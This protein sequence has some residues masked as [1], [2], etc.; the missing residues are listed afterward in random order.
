MLKEHLDALLLAL[1]SSTDNFMVGLSV[2]IGHTEL[3]LWVNG[4]ISVCNATGA[5]IAGYGGVMLS[6]HM[7]LLAPILASLAFALLALQEFRSSTF[8]SSDSA[9]PKKKFLEWSQVLQLALP[10]T[11]NNLAGGVAGGAA[12]LSPVVTSSYALLASF[13]T[14][15]VGHSIGHRLGKIHM[16]DPSL[17][18]GCLLGALCLL[19]LQECIHD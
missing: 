9:P 16:V 3:P 14:M 12:G 17:L 1:A 15:A 10:M 13:L 7:P 11:L 5:L 2:G 8:S 6:Q 19:T 4:F 18:S